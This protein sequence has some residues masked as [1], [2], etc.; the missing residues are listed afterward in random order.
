MR[1]YILYTAVISTLL[2][3][4]IKGSKPHKAP[5]MVNPSKKRARTST[6]ESEDDSDDHRTESRDF[7]RSQGL[8][9]EERRAC[10][11]LLIAE[12]TKSGTALYA[13]LKVAFPSLEAKKVIAFRRS[14]NRGSTIPKVAHD[15]IVE[16]AGELPDAF[17][18]VTKAVRQAYLKEGIPFPRSIRS[19]VARWYRSC[20]APATT[21][22]D[23]GCAVRSGRGRAVMMQMTGTTFERYL[24]DR[25]EALLPMTTVAPTT[26]VDESVND[27]EGVDGQ[28]DGE[29]S[30][31]RSSLD[32]LIQGT[33]DDAAR[34]S[35]DLL[36]Q[37]AGELDARV[38]LFP[39]GSVER[40]D[41]IYGMTNEHIL[42]AL[43]Y[44]DAS[45]NVLP[46]KFV[47]DLVRQCPGLDGRAAY[48]L[49]EFI[50]GRAA[51]PTAAHDIIVA[52][53][54][55]IPDRMSELVEILLQT[56]GTRW[57]VRNELHVMAWHKYCVR[58]SLLS[59][60][61]S[62]NCRAADNS[63][64]M[65][66]SDFQRTRLISDVRWEYIQSPIRIERMALGHMP[67]FLRRSAIVTADISQVDARPA[68]VYL[69]ATTAPSAVVPSRTRTVAPDSLPP[70]PLPAALKPVSRRS[71]HPPSPLSSTATRAVSRKAPRT[72]RSDLPRKSP[73]ESPRVRMPVQLVEDEVDLYSLTA[74]GAIL[75]LEVLKANENRTTAE[76]IADVRRSDPS[77]PVS[78][79]IPFYRDAEAEIR[80]AV[81][82][83]NEVLAHRNDF[84]KDHR[85][86]L[87]NV[88]GYSAHR[89]MRWYA[90]CVGPLMR[91]TE[92][93]SPCVAVRRGEIRFMELIGVHRARALD[94][95]I[96][97][98][99]QSHIRSPT[100]RPTVPMAPTTTTTSASTGTL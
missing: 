89:L 65:V 4:L 54:D 39:E 63:A 2:L 19:H 44:L 38:P 72:T 75:A 80:L 12:P 71:P 32:A 8:T 87:G 21:G 16:H 69:K 15:A 20:I 85:F 26:T 33:F 55:L 66:L 76:C 67:I 5:Q 18:N 82:A 27:V 3:Q 47:L 34:L 28:I 50:L 37:A 24:R 93:A 86:V 98:I 57:D 52:N 46:S 97:R 68:L 59:G 22:D 48:D 90:N 1:P 58:P 35:I 9:D 56:N 13:D 45:P 61:W 53:I 17:V 31:P 99:R 100:T 77:I 95:L 74:E 73:V 96:A 70:T 81:R 10:L 40:L 30:K 83:H 88:R 78:S 84:A 49:F 43:S 62:A 94:S 41:V 51:V 60:D 14:I 29:S 36:L 6:L 64:W 91:W 7:A 11:H 25:I 42:A 23:S 92:G 79:L